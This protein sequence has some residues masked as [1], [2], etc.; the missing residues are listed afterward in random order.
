MEHILFEVQSCIE[1]QIFNEFSE[2]P[3]NK[4]SFKSPPSFGPGDATDIDGGSDDDIP[5]TLPSW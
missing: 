5:T 4:K 2:F 3:T 1:I